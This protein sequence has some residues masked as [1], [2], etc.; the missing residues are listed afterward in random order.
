MPMTQ[1]EYLEN[2]G[3]YCPVCESTDLVFV[4]A[5]LRNVDKM[6]EHITCH[7]CGASWTDVYALEKYD[8]L[9]TKKAV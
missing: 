4:K 6:E 5:H 8:N 9:I 7:E 2:R 3:V 1:E